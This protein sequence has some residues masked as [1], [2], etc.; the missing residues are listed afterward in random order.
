VSQWR[1]ALTI[2][3]RTLQPQADKHSFIILGVDSHKI[4][5]W[6][7]ANAGTPATDDYYHT[8]VR[9]EMRCCVA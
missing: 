3:A 8:L 9:V 2:L 4:Y 7:E 6:H 1:V 5:N